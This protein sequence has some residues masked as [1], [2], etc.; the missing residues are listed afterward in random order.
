MRAVVAVDTADRTAGAAVA[1][2][3]AV[4]AQVVEQAAPRQAQRILGMVEACLHAAGVRRGDL[5]AV[6]VTRGPGAFTGLRVG[7]ATA[8]A[9]GLALGIPV[10]GVSTLEALAGSAMPWPGHV[11][12]VLDAKKGQVYA[13]VW[14]GR[15]GGSVLAEGAWAPGALAERVRQAGEPALF[16]GSGVEPYGRLF[17]EILGELFQGCPPERWPVPPGRVALMGWEAWAAGRAVAPARLVPVYHRRS[18]AEEAR[19][20]RKP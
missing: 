20:R 19:L 18:E 16:L 14:D 17:R 7:L 13:G 12:P 10:V 2:E 3:G 5:V 9:I 1:V 4:R 11:V 15:T 6:A 8:K